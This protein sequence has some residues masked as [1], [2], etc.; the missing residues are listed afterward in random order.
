MGD[1][2]Q[3]KKLMIIPILATTLFANQSERQATLVA[4]YKNMFHEIGRK[5]VGVDTNTVDRLKATFV[6]LEKKKKV[7][8]QGVK[9]SKKAKVFALEAIVAKSAKINGKWHSIG[10]KVHGMKIISVRNNYVWLKN[11]EFR[12]KLIL[13]KKNEKISIK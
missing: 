8:T 11:D 13:G 3:M 10:G 7:D 5:R 2:I 12:K 9:K 1:G 4:K 6:S